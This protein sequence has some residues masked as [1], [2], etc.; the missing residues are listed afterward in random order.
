MKKPRKKPGKKTLVPGERTRRATTNLPNPLFT[1]AVKRA[2]RCGISAYLRAL[3][4]HDF[5]ACA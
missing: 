1:K 3:V 2:G 4:E 5:E